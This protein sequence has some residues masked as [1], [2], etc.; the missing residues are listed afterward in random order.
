MNGPLRILF[1]LLLAP[2]AL[3]VVG[4]V[5]VPFVSNDDRFMVFANKRF[6]K[7]EPRPPR[8][9]I[10][11]E[12]HVVYLDH[13]G[14]LRVFRE[15]GRRLYQL[16][17][18]PPT[19]LAHTRDRLAWTVADTLKTLSAGK[20]KVIATG[21]ERF[22]VGDS[23]IVY[24]DSAANELR[25]WYRREVHV[26]ADVEQGTK[27]PQWVQGGN[28]VTF[29][30]RS[31]YRLFL[32]HRGGVHVLADSTDVGL[33]VNGTDLV[34]FWR[35]REKE[36][37]VYDGDSTRVLSDMRPLSAK[38]GDRLLAYVDGAGRLRC[39]QDGRVHRLTDTIPTDY[40]VQDGLLLY[41]QGG[42]LMLFDPLGPV[43][44]EPYVPERWV[45]WG[46]RLVYLDINRELRS[47]E[48]GRRIRLA[49]EAAIPRFDVYGD[50][51]VYP[52]PTGTTTVLRGGRQYLY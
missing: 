21:V 8:Q 26:L 48:G 24:H 18:A 49:N 15:E 23:M 40:W 11:Q 34:G 29:Y 9:V 36:W 33:T 47:I 12:G 5:P 13:E 22:T 44:V 46:D 30:D 7:L 19:A 6:E 16:E 2:L 41:L 38:A 35:S 39:Y 37:C 42:A 1:L 28:T 14:R 31:T 51:V 20:G 52:S 3:Q 4:Q 50:A 25:A 32:F 27:A 17:P 45:V 43:R 10:A